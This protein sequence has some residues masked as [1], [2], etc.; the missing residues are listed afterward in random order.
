MC[1]LTEGLRVRCET[2]PDKA[3]VIRGKV[4]LF[5][6]DGTL[7]DSRSVIE[8][9]WRSWA[10]KHS[11]D[12]EAILAF[13]HGRRA[14]DTVR[15]FAPAGMDPIA[16]AT[17]LSVE[18]KENTTALSA[19]RGAAS[20]L[21]SLPIGSWAVVTSADRLLAVRWMFAAGLPIPKILVTAEDVGES[22]PAPEG[23]LLAASRLASTSREAIVFEDSPTGIAAGR[24][25]GASVITVGSMLEGGERGKY[26]IP[27]FSAA[28][29][30]SDHVGY[31]TFRH[32]Q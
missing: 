15:L 7:I 11:I 24:A 30:T 14:L 8:R 12:P 23:Y 18:A 16:E 25:A 27:D 3:F 13:S 2:S 28:H 22:K 5:D 9:I 6:M 32:G 21:R 20:L 26:W 31:V 1:R 19:R 17:R 4:L 10:A 29:V